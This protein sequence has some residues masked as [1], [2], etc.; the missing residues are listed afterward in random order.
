MPITQEPADS[1]LWPYSITAENN[2]L[3]RKRS[4]MWK[5]IK[6]CPLQRNRT[7]GLAENKNRIQHHLISD[8]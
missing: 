8:G 6:R 7:S 1:S 3:V 2:S 5:S 4:L